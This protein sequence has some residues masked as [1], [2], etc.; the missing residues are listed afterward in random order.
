MARS[1]AAGLVVPAGAVTDLKTLLKYLDRL[2]D[3]IERSKSQPYG[4]TTFQ[5]LHPIAT[6]MGIDYSELYDAFS[7]LENI[8]LLEV[9]FRS[10]DEALERIESGISGSFAPELASKRAELVQALAVYTQDNPILLAFKSQ[11]LAYLYQN[12]YRDAEL[13]TDSRP[14]F[15]SDGDK[16]LEFMVSHSLAITYTTGSSRS[17]RIHLTL[18]AGDVLKLRKACDRAILK[19]KTLKDALGKSAE[20]QIHI[21]RDDQDAAG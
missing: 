12:I 1:N 20:W 8:K 13:I 15:N 4:I 6:S 21:L 16:V 5:V 19:A 10:A 7:A 11:R 18:D 2:P 14:I 17:E 3:V 9:E